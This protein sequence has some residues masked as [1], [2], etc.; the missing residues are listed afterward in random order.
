MQHKSFNIS[1]YGIQLLNF[2][3]V[4]GL[5][6]CFW[7]ISSSAQIYTE[8]NPERIMIGDTAALNIT[9]TVDSDRVV[10]MPQLSDS[11][12]HYIEVSAVKM[13]SL[14]RGRNLN[15]I[16]NITLTG[17][18]PG[19]FLIKGLPITIDGETYLSKPFTLSIQDVE[20]DEN[21]Q[22]LFSIKPIME[23]DIT[24]WERNKQYIYYIVAGVLFILIILLIIW[25]Y[26]RE[27]KRQKYISTPL[28][29]PYEEALDNL[30]KLD[31]EQY[32]DKEKYYEFYSDL[33]F[34]IRRY[35]Q[36]RFDF[37]AMALL[38]SDLAEV[39]RQKDY[40]TAEESVE[41]SKFLKDA[42]FT[43]YARQVPSAEKHAHY[44]AW[45]EEIINRTRPVL[46]ETLPDHI[47]SI[48]DS[49]KIRKIDRS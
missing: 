7:V 23:Q 44:R 12:S 19:E 2:K 8:L 20:V 11:L 26:Y 46:D 41:F 15:I 10:E 37:P 6:L 18:E 9:V 30:D 5:W 36:R 43:K 24:W 48:D 33:S 22:G 49:E 45:I 29:P 1:T 34:I 39:M 28:L 40:L 38:S 47:P 32:V 27:K 35:F 4:L 14:Q 31:K 3:K 16:Q 42:D 13:D 21:Q 25:L 17:F